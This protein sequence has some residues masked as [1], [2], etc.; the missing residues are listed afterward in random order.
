[1]KRFGWKFALI[2]GFTLA[3][4][5]NIWP[6]SQKLKLGIDLSGGTILVYEVM[7]D[8]LPPGFKM[9][10][11]IAALKKRA[12]PDGIKEIPIRNIGNNRIEIILPQASNEEVEE[13]KKMLTDVGSLEFRILANRKHDE[14]VIARALGSGGTAKPPSRYKW[15]RLGGDL[16]RN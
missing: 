11:L 8:Q 3:G 7:R 4:L 6:P 16:D 2:I 14:D 15:A 12:D 9:D 1:M 10:E 13:V 5:L